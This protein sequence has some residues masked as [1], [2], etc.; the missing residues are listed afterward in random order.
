MKNLSI[1]IA[2]I[3]LLSFSCKTKHNTEVTTQVQGQTVDATTRPTTKN[4]KTKGKVS[5]EFRATGCNTVIVV[6]TDDA[7]NPLVLIPI[8][9]LPAEFD[10]D[11]ID[12]YFN[13][14]LSRMKNPEGCMKGIPAEV[15]DI[16]LK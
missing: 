4:P 6:K 5:H 8:S 14:R 1:I 11:G 13:Y 15:T 10:K 16:S 3:T 2:I 9:P 7:A 12:L